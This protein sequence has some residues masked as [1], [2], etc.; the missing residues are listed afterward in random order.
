MSKV[1]CLLSRR[2]KSRDRYYFLGNYQKHVDEQQQ[3]KHRLRISSSTGGKTGKAIEKVGIPVVVNLMALKYQQGSGANSTSSPFEDRTWLMT[4]SVL[5]LIILSFLPITLRFVRLIL[6]SLVAAI[7]ASVCL[8]HSCSWVSYPICAFLGYY[9]CYLLSSVTCTTSSWSSFFYDWNVRIKS[10][11]VALF[12]GWCWFFGY[13][14]EKNQ[15][16][17]SSRPKDVRSKFTLFGG[18]CGI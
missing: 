3:G 15:E 16:D 5:L 13:A 11:A 10:K 18:W 9:N 4:I 14:V 17:N 1:I 12:G 6:S 8:P 2:R 7:F